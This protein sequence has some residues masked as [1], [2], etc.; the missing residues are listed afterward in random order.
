MLSAIASLLLSLMFA[1]WL[2]LLCSLT[3]SGCIDLLTIFLCF[4]R[5]WWCRR[6]FW[7]KRLRNLE[8]TPHPF[9]EFSFRTKPFFNSTQDHPNNI[10]FHLWKCMI[11]VFGNIHCFWMNA[12]TLIER[13]ILR[14]PLIHAWIIIIFYL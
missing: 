4:L 1:E 13:H 3:E 6:I 8:D 10:S 14:K 5:L 12:I 7:Q 9:S 11:F 2:D